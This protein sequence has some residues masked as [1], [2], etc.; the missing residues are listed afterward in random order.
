MDYLVM[1]FKLT[2]A[3]AIFIGLINDYFCKFLDKSMIVFL[4]DIL[5]YNQIL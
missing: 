4:D 5:I 1:P 3:L 2:N